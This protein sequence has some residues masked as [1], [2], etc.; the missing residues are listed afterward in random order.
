MT[1]PVYAVVDIE[2]TGLDAQ[3]DVPLELG[4]I[5]ID[6]VGNEL[7]SHSWTVYETNWM[8]QKGIKRGKDNPYV[9]KMH[10][11]NNLWR[12]IGFSGLNRNTVDDRA[13]I[14]LEENGVHSQSRVSG[15][16]F[17]GI[18]MMGNSTGSLDRPFTLFHFP[19]LNQYLGHRNIDMSSLKEVCKRNNPHLWKQIEP[20]VG[21]KKD[22]VHRVLEDCRVC[23]R[24]FQ[25]YLDE[26]LIVED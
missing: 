18:G 4:I 11:E 8:F 14:W 17:D 5:L 1:E 7:A 21:F 23:I 25:T 12:D 9:N 16:E 22:A 26:F 2:T 13:C 3:L 20:L 15:A 19:M 24:E 6:K 10:T